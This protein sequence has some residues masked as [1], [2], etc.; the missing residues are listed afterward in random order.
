[1]RRRGGLVARCIVVGGLLAACG[2]GVTAGSAQL[3]PIPS[4]AEPDP[5]AFDVGPPGSAPPTTVAVTTTTVVGTDDPIKALAARPGALAPVGY[6]SA[7][8]PLPTVTCATLAGEVGGD[9]VYAVTRVGLPPVFVLLAVG[10]DGRFAIGD[11]YGPLSGMTPPA[12]VAGLGTYP[13]GRHFSPYDL[14]FRE[15]RRRALS[16]LVE[17]P[18]GPVNGQWCTVY[19]V[20]DPLTVRVQVQA[21]PGGVSETWDVEYNPQIDRYRWRGD[22]PV[23]TPGPNR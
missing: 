4:I 22:S 11:S 20:V 23:P 3:S 9:R 18:N 15:M 19:E 17:C 14:V 12:W 5:P 16:Q 8:A 10:D 1:M 6:C 2:S 13:T 7:Y 21:P